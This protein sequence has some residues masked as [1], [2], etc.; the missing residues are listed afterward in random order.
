MKTRLQEIKSHCRR[1][2]KRHFLLACALGLADWAITWALV[3]A[4]DVYVNPVYEQ[5]ACVLLF[6]SIPLIAALWVWGY[7]KNRDLFQLDPQRMARRIENSNTHLNDLLVTA[8]DLGERRN[9]EPNPLER[10]VL[11]SAVEQL[12]SI[13]W[14]RASTHW[15]ERKRTVAAIGILACL[16]ALSV[17]YTPAMK[18]AGYFM[19][20]WASGS[21]SG[22]VIGAF[23]DEVAI[24]T[25]V[26]LS[27]NVNRW[28]QAAEIQWR[29]AN[30]SHTEPVV[31]DVSGSGEFT[32][33]AME[34]PV[35]FRFSTP[36]LKSE[37]QE[38]DVY[39]PA[40]LDRVDLEVRPPAYTRI[41]PVQ[42]TS[43]ADLTVPEGSEVMVRL[44][45][46]SAAAIQLQMDDLSQPVP[47]DARQ[48]FQTDFK[49]TVSGPYQFILT[50][51]AG[52]EEKSPV[53]K[54]EILPD[55]P[56]VVEILEPEQDRVLAPDQELLLHVYSADDYGLAEARVH[57]K[58][59]NSGE[60]VLDLPVSDSE[61]EPTDEPVLESE[62]RAGV[63]LEELRASDGEFLA[64]HVEVFDNREP[65][66]N[67]TR[68][69]LLF[70]EIRT[71][72]P[73]EERDGMPMDQ[74]EINL[75]E[76]IDE[77]KRILRE[78]DRLELL[79]RD[80]RT[81]RLPELIS[82]LSALGV[83]INRVF[84]EIRPD[85]EAAGRADL[86]ELFKE[87]G[88]GN[89]R[90]IS[91]LEADRPGQSF[92]PQSTSLS[93]LLKLENAF[94]Q[95]TISKNPSKGSGKGQSEGQPSEEQ[96][97]G[98]ETGK[99]DL[100]KLLEAKEALESMV[101]EQN[102]LN[103]GYDRATRSDWA[104]ESA[105]AAAGKQRTLA[106]QSGE[107][108]DELA[109]VRESGR[110]RSFLNSAR[111]HMSAAA[112][113]ASQTD[114]SGSLRS[115]LRA[116]ESM[117]RA[118]AEL[119]TMIAEAS[120]QQLAAAAQAAAQLARRQAEAAAASQEAAGG[121][122]TMDELAG[123]EAAQRALKERYENFLEALEE[124]ARAS[125]SV[126]PEASQALMEAAGEA[127]SQSTGS[128][129]ERAANAL[130]YGQPGMAAPLQSSAAEQLAGL[131]E[132]L[133]GA[134][135]Q[136]GNNPLARA[137]A[138]NR[139]LMSALE[140]LASYAREP[141]AVPENRLEELRGD[142]SERMEELREISGDPRFGNLSGALGRTNP[143]DGPG[144][145]ADARMLLQQ[146]A[147]LLN[148]FLF[149][150]AA[151]SG[152]QINRQAAPPP[153]EYR[154]MV[155]E[156]FRRLANEPSSAP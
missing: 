94:R 138:L 80:E 5:T 69:D 71:P 137:R 142:W 22:L 7:R 14:K 66:A 120:G 33:Y 2:N 145:I 42:H 9:G 150:E 67:R 82:N 24:G 35:R 8:A 131:S 49:P 78:T 72:V 153:D 64:L 134:R 108:G 110:L 144:E 124:Q 146:G 128:D 13:D 140:E 91:E 149:N 122:P 47:L 51:T 96:K 88:T 79:P 16:M 4:W 6:I 58:L 84:T 117:R 19:S 100:D 10:H 20:D 70:I 154:R 121:N 105:M 81:N 147:R 37:W 30:G 97:D 48:L 130:L 32:L 34:S 31:V 95:N 52:R 21:A 87:A 68:T 18:K 29:D 116:R 57:L 114:A 123:M 23:P 60:T 135:E 86:I 44:H 17:A 93:N 74:K 65:V 12:S 92:E 136:L 50:D 133:S 62:I 73:P 28:E 75:R 101:S 106:E 139:E 112:L 63:S 1:L 99:Q 43:L 148:E 77:Q 152:M 111:G 40:R 90:A 15:P 113:E 129:M 107:L 59:S 119:D 27:I 76:L 125:A 11:D 156:Y 155:E 98:Q 118:A 143:G 109:D 104:A 36:S 39:Q 127:R 151:F 61:L 83:E 26:T 85:L 102:Q 126:S 132:A 3:A 25:D 54:I 45:S 103:S 115:G 56:P 38:I 41:D 89:L 141:E 46:Q 53:R 55:R